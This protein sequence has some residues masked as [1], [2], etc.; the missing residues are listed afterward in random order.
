MRNL[1]TKILICLLGVGGLIAWSVV[2]RDAPQEPVQFNRD[3]RPILSENCSFCHGPDET[4]NKSALRLDLRDAAI[5]AGAIVPGDPDSSELI[6]R[7]LSDDPAEVM[8]RPDTHK[9]LTAKQKQQLVQWVEAGAPYEAHWS[10]KPVQRPDYASI[11][12]IVADALQKRDLRFADPADKT[13]LVRRVFLDVTGLPPTP[14]QAAA[15]LEDASENAYEE[16]IDRLLASPHYGENMA[17][18][19]LDLVRFTDTVGY[20]GDQNRDASPFR[21]YVIEA[22]NK[23]MPFDQF[24][25]EQIAGDLLPDPSLRQRIAASYNHLNQ[26]SK[27]GGVQDKEYIKKYQAERVRSTATAWMG[28]TLACAECHDHKFDPFTTKDFY[29]FAAFFADILEKGAWT[30]DGH[31]QEEV[32]TYV[33]RLGLHLPQATGI[34]GFGPVIPVPNRSFIKAPAS[35]ENELARREKALLTGT[36]AAHAEFDRWFA[37]EQRLHRL[38]VKSTHVFDVNSADPDALPLALRLPVEAIKEMTLELG[39]LG[40]DKQTDGEFGLLL[41]AESH[42]V[43]VVWGKHLAREGV[44]AIRKKALT[45]PKQV[46]TLKLDFKAVKLPESMKTLQSVEFVRTVDGNEAPVFDLRK[47]TVDTV[48]YQVPKGQLAAEDRALLERCCGE[49]PSPEDLQSVRFAYLAKHAKTADIQSLQRHFAVLEDYLNGSRY[50]PATVSAKPREVRVL[51]RGNWMD[52][53][54]DLVLPRTP[55]FLPGFREPNEPNETEPLTRLDLARWLVCR[56]HPLTARTYV[57]RLWAQFFG[58]ALSKASEDLGQQGEYPVYPELL[59]WLAAEFMDS[60]WNVKHMVKLMV[61]S[62]TYQQTSHATPALEQHD[63]YNRLLAR[64][65]PR[66]LP[67][68]AI[69][70]NALAAS[71]LLLRRVGGRSVKPYQPAGYYQHLNFPRRSYQAEQNENQYRRGLYTHW[72]RTF[73]HPMLMAFDAPGR[74]ECTAARPQSNT[75]LQALN[76]LNDPSFLE[77]AKALADRILSAPADDG[78][79]LNRAFQAA[80]LRSPSGQEAT[81]LQNYLDRERDRFADDPQAA[82]AMLAVGQ[83]QVKAVHPAAEIAAWMSLCRAIFNLHE[84]ITRY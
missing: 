79:R 35:L 23:N 7:V 53:T 54:G 4:N 17:I 74:D 19:W 71:G 52:E 37:E 1:I 38:G 64:Q 40:Q 72:Q 32:E 18:Y 68:E 82:Q 6:R 67:A 78:A 73:L 58:T 16:L 29:S 62:R 50:V 10:Y 60:G 43:L 3:I 57:N 5:A 8:P 49:N 48:R 63:P 61:I 11:D 77:A 36:P 42:S 15:F 76:L 39:Y 83:Y 34:A 21:D 70:D 33:E 2:N 81:L 20:H 47:L 56:D 26:V 31:Y 59:E 51:P 84:T 22:F 41:H 66:R 14:A 28:S 44:Q 46:N 65:S 55:Q 12:A 75:P 9:T 80:L 25:I 27:E 69:R 13:T 24:T 45:H 30:G